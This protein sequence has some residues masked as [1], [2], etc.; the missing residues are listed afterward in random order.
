MTDF[1]AIVPATDLSPTIR[2]IG[3]SKV[4]EGAGL[5]AVSLYL[6][7]DGRRKMSLEARL[8]VAEACGFRVQVSVK[9]PRRYGPKSGGGEVSEQ[10]EQCA[11]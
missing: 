2:E 1:D 3:V 4:A 5:T 8:R 7:L 6:W 10:P 9:P 11:G